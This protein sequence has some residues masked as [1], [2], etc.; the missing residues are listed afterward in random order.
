MNN[1]EYTCFYCEPCGLEWHTQ[2]YYTEVQ[3][4]PKCN[5]GNIYVSEL[6]DYI[7]KVCLKCNK[8]KEL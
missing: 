4:C 7:N 3:I 6:T 1:K 8:E 5:S 2:E